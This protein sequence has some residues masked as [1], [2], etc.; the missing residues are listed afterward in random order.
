MVMGNVSQIPGSLFEPA[1]T[2]TMLIASE[3]DEAG[4]LHRGALFGAGL[5]LLLAVAGLTL[6]V[7]ARG[8]DAR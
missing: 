3:M 6:L 7:P 8:R 5:L 1:R 2:L 4:G